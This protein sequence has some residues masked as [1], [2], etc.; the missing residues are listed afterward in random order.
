MRPGRGFPPWGRPLGLRIVPAPVTNRPLCQP[1][2][3][4]TLAKLL[5]RKGLPVD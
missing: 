1:D 5:I 2:H 3:A 4:T